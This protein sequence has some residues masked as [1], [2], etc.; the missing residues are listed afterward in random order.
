[1]PPLFSPLPSSSPTL[2]R[3][4]IALALACSQVLNSTIL[5]VGGRIDDERFVT[6]KKAV[7]ILVQSLT[8][9]PDPQ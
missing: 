8:G 6:A 4:L 2:V 7:T 9:S 5:T 3:M 1:M